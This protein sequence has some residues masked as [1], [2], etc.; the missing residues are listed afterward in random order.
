[1]FF[2]LSKSKFDF[3]NLKDKDIS[4]SNGEN[5]FAYF[6]LFSLKKK[7]LLLSKIIFNGI[8]S[9][10]KLNGICKLISFS[11]FNSKFN[12]PETLL[13]SSSSRAVSKGISNLIIIGS[14][15]LVI[16]FIL[17]C[18]VIKLFSLK[19]N[20]DFILLSMKEIIL[21]LIISP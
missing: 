4:K 19:F 2:H 13:Y 6:K 7:P 9:K 17:N 10:L 5:S 20:E 14:L 16:E 12:S 3:S 8:N 18:F 21:N 1:M 15:G 11:S